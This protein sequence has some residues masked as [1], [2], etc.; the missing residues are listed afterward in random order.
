M[1]EYTAMYSLSIICH[2]K[3]TN[4][5]KH[6]VSIIFVALFYLSVIL[7]HVQDSTVSQ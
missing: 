3:A 2:G 4:R 5:T 1:W 7:L 6:G